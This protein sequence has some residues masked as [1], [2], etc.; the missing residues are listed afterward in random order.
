MTSIPAKRGRAPPIAVSSSSLHVDFASSTEVSH[1]YRNNIII[2]YISG[3]QLGRLIGL[4]YV[5]LK[6]IEHSKES[7]TPTMNNTCPT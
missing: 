5:N 4:C 6:R 2:V 1:R 3:R 7:K